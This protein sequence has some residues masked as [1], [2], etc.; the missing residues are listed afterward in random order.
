MLYRINAAADAIRTALED[1][2][3]IVR[4]AAARVLGLSK[5]RQCV[6]KLMELVQ[7]DEAPVRRQAATALGQIGDSRAISALIKASSNPNDRFVEHAI[8]YALITLREPE[9]LVQA[10]TD[11]SAPVRKLRS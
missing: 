10:L 4:T 9:L 6:A 11:A 8:I 3:A 2:S 1:K 7:T 5:D